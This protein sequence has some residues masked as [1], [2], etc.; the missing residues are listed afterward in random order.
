MNFLINS[1]RELFL[2]YLFSNLYA[3]FYVLIAGRFPD[4]NIVDNVDVGIGFVVFAAMFIVLYYI[5]LYPVFGFLVR[6]NLR[7][8]YIDTGVLPIDWRFLHW[9]ILFLQS[10]YFLFVLYFDAGK[11][12]AERI[13]IPFSGFWA[14]IQIDF[15]A[16]YYLMSA[17]K[18]G[19]WR[20][21]ILLYIASNFVRGWTGFVLIVGFIYLIRRSS[22]LNI[23]LKK[24]TILI[25]LI[26][27]I[28]PLSLF[29]KFY[30][31]TSQFGGDASDFLNVAF[32]FDG[33]TDLFLYSFGYFLNRFQQLS[34][35]WYVWSASDFISTAYQGGLIA[36]IWAENLYVN[37]FLKLFGMDIVPNLG[38][39]STLYMPYSFDVVLG[40]FN[41]SPGLLGW[42]SVA[43]SDL[44]GFWM[45]LFCI[46]SVGFLIIQII[47]KFG[48]KN[49]SNLSSL[50][51]LM[52]LL[53]LLP[54]WINQ[55]IAFL[56]AGLMYIL[57]LVVI[58]N[59]VNNRRGL[60]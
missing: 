19:L 12:G 52:W 25:C 21:N 8:S 5:L 60:I 7:L 44:L 17:S 47:S 40:S 36:P 57:I 33:Y 30:I 23:N 15:L 54:G 9:I 31:R 16:V 59:F 2:I 14:V 42:I 1:R 32:G 41:I 11:V 4:V 22:P 13:D 48:S 50:L 26:C 18:N 49:W 43:G 35:T 38:I 28:L 46:I 20:A 10:I 3:F 55:Y 45:F 34:L 53:L 6:V 27:L 24:F 58:R 39:Y 37:F 51:W 29:F 56:H